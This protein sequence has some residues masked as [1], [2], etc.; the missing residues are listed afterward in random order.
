MT[1]AALH[2]YE[3]YQSSDKSIPVIVRSR[4]P[5]A[6]VEGMLVFNLEESKRNGIFELESGLGH[7]EVVQVE[8]DCKPSRKRLIDAGAF[9][10]AESLDG[11]VPIKSPFWDPTPFVNSS[12]YQNIEQSVRRSAEDISGS[13]FHP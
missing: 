4:N 5:K 2:G 11:L 3:L 9:L 12:F 13:W 6:V 1:K 8:I 10:R 7:L